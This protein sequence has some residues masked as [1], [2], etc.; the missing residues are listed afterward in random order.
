MDI[1]KYLMFSISFDVYIRFHKQRVIGT[2][3][4]TYICVPFLDAIS[5]KYKKGQL[6]S[7][8]AV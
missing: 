8:L 5:K 3:S 1:M 4:E 7:I 2:V 6:F